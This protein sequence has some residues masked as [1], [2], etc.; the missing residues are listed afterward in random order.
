[1][2]A[3]C[4]LA[5]LA[6]CFSMTAQQRPPATQ[7]PPKAAGK[8]GKSPANA[9][10]KKAVNVPQHEAWLRS[11]TLREKIAQLLVIPFYGE[12]PPAKSKLY[13]KYRREVGMLRVGGIILVNHTRN[14]I[15]QYADPQL[16]A[17]FLNRMQKV[18]RIPLIAG[19]DLERG[20]SM[21]LTKAARF[22]HAMAFAAARE[23]EGTRQVGE[24][25]ARESRAVGIHWIF[26]PVADV[27]NNPDN[28]VINIRSYGE[29]PADVSAHVKAFIEGARRNPQYPV[30]VT[31]K[32]FPGHG[33]TAVD[34]HAGLG[35]IDAPMERIRQLELAPF[36]AAI[37]AKVDSVMTAHLWV[38]ALEPSPLPAT[39]SKNVLTGVLRQELSFDGII[40][41][42]AMD[43]HGL[44]KEFAPGEAS[45]RAIEAGVDV[46]LMPPDP[47]ESVRAIAAA[48]KSGR[49]T[50]K[51]IEES[52]RKLLLAKVQLGLH[53]KR[54]VDVK[55]I[56]GLLGQPEDEALAQRVAGNALTLVRN[57]GSAVP[58]TGNRTACWYVLND[59]SRSPLG[60]RMMEVLRARANTPAT[61][62]FADSEAAAFE[63][64]VKVAGSCDANVVAVFAGYR[65][66]GQ[67]AEA[68]NGLLQKLLGAGKPVIM[69]GM[70]NPYLVRA[71]PAVQGFVATF[72]TVPASEDAVVKALYGE[73]G[74]PGRMPVSIP[75]LAA[76][77]AGAG[78]VR[79]AQ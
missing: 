70:G 36:R 46:L 21:R 43:M 28:P 76:Y 71:Y 31:A 52:V 41:T 50:Q 65:G 61:R 37:Q 53:Q 5:A 2:K 7:Q 42:D 26:A 58:V 35:R 12:N 23:V 63:E 24:V 64:A 48:V 78:E 39:V 66:N 16:S 20:A 27:N 38:P 56:P 6:A 57:E 55:A 75:G 67:L 51:R 3:L 45:V 59:S 13:Q 34:T 14:G 79:P 32:H 15:V 77:G 11:M 74:M 17:G 68:H 18:A 19:A 62:L 69:L 9:K 1:M 29:N 25:T 54:Y 40:S 4:V 73:V 47:A 10:K 30:L 22:P 60:V 33:D 8:A 49:L 72:S 44:S